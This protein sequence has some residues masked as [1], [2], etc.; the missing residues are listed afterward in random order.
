MSIKYLNEAWTMPLN[1]HE[2]MVLLAIAD[3]S[4]DEGFAFPGYEKLLKKT[5][6]G[7]E[8][9]AKHIRILK[10]LSIIKVESHAEIGKGKK[11]NTYT[12]S[13]RSELPY[14]SDLELIGKIK[15][16]R[17]ENKKSIS[18]HLE[19][20]KVRTSN[21]I[22]SILEHEPSV[23]TTSKEPSVKEKYKKEKNQEQTTKPKKLKSIHFE[24]FWKDYPEKNQ[25]IP[26]LKKWESKN[27]D[28][29]AAIIIADV[30]ARKKD[31]VRWLDGYIPNP[32]TYINQERWRDEIKT[33]RPKRQQPSNYQKSG[34]VITRADWTSSD[35]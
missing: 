26:C 19:L 27:L 15:E 8:A 23:I 9:L 29:H 13:T 10:G 12:I 3:C 28:K 20:R 30:K 24:E 7:R 31:D 17:Q 2:K 33:E 35:F 34:N 25:R 21:S 32:L 22:S 11:V 18:S 16:L 6:M 14:S 1:T 4:N 5:G